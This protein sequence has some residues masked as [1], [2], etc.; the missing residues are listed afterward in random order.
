[1]AT[2][3]LAGVTVGETAGEDGDAALGDETTG[4]AVG[5]AGDAACFRRGRWVRNR[6]TARLLSMGEAGGVNGG[7][8]VGESEAGAVI[9]ATDSEIVGEAGDDGFGLM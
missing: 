8:V 7:E 9:D 3:R 2:A 4:E 1:M 6:P 5:E